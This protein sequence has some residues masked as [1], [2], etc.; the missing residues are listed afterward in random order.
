MRRL[1][2]VLVGT[3]LLFAA[4]PVSSAAQSAGVVQRREV[5]R[6]RREAAQDDQE[7]PTLADRRR[8][9][10]A[11]RTALARTVRQRL[12]LTDVQATQLVEVN[13]RFAGERLQLAGEEMQIRR[14]LRFA[15]AS[16]DSSRS[17]DTARLLDSL[18]GIQRR[19]VDVRQR[20]QTAL[21]EFLTPEQRARYIGMMEQ[22]R[23]RIQ[24]RTDSVRRRGRRPE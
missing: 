20:E 16:G 4:T 22:L 7:G 9:E 17:S 15:V 5:A 23:R 24:V 10:R 19:H 12:N 2:G 1:H 8:A 21:S 18:L 3:W 6:E 11:L 13:R 14:D